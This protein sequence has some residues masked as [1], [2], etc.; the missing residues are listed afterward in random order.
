MDIQL[1]EDDHVPRVDELSFCTQ[2]SFYVLGSWRTF[3][4]E[5]QQGKCMR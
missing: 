5:V 2:N 4:L 1:I 3:P